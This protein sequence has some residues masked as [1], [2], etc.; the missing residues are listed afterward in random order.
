MSGCGGC[1]DPRAGG[2]PRRAERL[3]RMGFGR[4]H[5]PYLPDRLGCGCY[6]GACDCARRTFTDTA[7]TMARRAAVCH[8]S[9]CVRMRGD[10]LWVHA[11]AARFGI[12]SGTITEHG[13]T[14]RELLEPGAFRV[15]LAR[16]DRDVDIVVQHD[17]ALR[18]A[19]WR[20]PVDAS[21]ARIWQDSV[22]LNFEFRL[23]DTDLGARTL[24]Q[25][26]N[27]TLGGASFVMTHITDT[28]R[29]TDDGWTRRIHSV[30]R[31]RDVSLVG[32]GAY[33]V[34][35]PEPVAA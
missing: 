14:F 30:G 29:E 35:P 28:W 7:P 15:A 24:A 32:S 16:P 1:R 6:R 23:P 33:T 3:A 13:R 21:T 26:E 8:A 18:L 19:R 10:E 12:W 25:I 11:L 5:S 17:P 27:R 31:L 34:A 4:A 20:G 22:G 9:A 2:D